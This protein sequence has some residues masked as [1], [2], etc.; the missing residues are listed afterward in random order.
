MRARILEAPASIES[1]ALAQAAYALADIARVPRVAVP[2][3]HRAYPFP[4]ARLELFRERHARAF[5]A[6]HRRD[7]RARVE[8]SEL[9]L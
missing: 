3:V 6:H 2:A 9:V 7:V 4:R 8:L 5:H 1:S